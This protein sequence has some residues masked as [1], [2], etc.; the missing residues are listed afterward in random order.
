MMKSDQKPGGEAPNQFKGNGGTV[1]IASTMQ[2]HSDAK[3]RQKSTK[4]D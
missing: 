3:N 4:N 1:A 2:G